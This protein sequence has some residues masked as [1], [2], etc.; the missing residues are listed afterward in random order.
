MEAEIGRERQKQEE[1]TTKD[2]DKKE[3]SQTR[4]KIR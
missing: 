1:G 4:R 3:R 2:E